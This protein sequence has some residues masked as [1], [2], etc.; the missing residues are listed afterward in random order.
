MDIFRFPDRDMV[1]RFYWGSAVGHAYAHAQSS[2]ERCEDD[3]SSVSEAL[4]GDDVL[5]NDRE[6]N[7]GDSQLEFTLDVQDGDEW[8]DPDDDMVD[9]DDLYDSTAD[10]L[11]APMCDT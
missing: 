6:I 3:I 8:D 9:G 5:E 10:E 2:R 7:A 1:M 11:F 4:N